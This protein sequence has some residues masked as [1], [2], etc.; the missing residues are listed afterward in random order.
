MWESA[1]FPFPQESGKQ[2]DNKFCYKIFI[3]DIHRFRCL[4]A[5]LALRY[6]KV[7]ILKYTIRVRPLTNADLSLDCRFPCTETDTYNLHRLALIKDI[8]N[9]QSIDEIISNDNELFIT[10]DLNASALS[11]D[12]KAIFNREFCY[13][14]FDGIECHA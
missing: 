3:K 6:T 13:I 8:R 14:R 12:M 10:S 1:S 11:A 9:L 7:T 4:V 2:P 5:H